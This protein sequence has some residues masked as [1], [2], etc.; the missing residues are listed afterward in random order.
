[1]A[2]AIWLMS[3]SGE[4]SKALLGLHALTGS[5]YTASFY[6]KGKEIPFNV[7]V[8]SETSAWVHALAS[9]SGGHNIEYKG[10]ESFVCAIY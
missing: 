8:K 7:I 4:F 1:M 3:K 9:M 5:D 2:K 6:K 10:I